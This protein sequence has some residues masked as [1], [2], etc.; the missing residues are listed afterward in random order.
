WAAS[1]GHA[2]LFDGSICYDHCYFNDPGGNYRT[3][4]ANFRSLT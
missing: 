4:Q 2:R 3:D 1:G